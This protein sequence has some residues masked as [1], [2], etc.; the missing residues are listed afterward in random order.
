MKR[1]RTRHPPLG[2]LEL[3][4]Q[5]RA[6]VMERDGV[7]LQPEAWRDFQRMRQ[8]AKRSGIDLCVASSFR[9]FATQVRIWN[10]KWHG[11]RPL[12]DRRGRPMNAARLKPTARVRAILLW[13][14]PP[15]ASRHHWGSDLDVYDRAAL[16]KDQRLQLVPAEYAETGPFA[17]LTT[18]LNANMYRFGFYRPYT[19]DR[20]GVQ[21]EPWHLS[22]IASAR[23]VS[24][25]LRL[26]TL[27]RALASSEL[28]GRAAL[29]ANLPVV[30]SRFIR[31]VDRPPR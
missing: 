23:E 31:S 27:R 16:R 24:K 9:D 22:H 14:A 20:G 10:Q 17:A 5:S 6:H 3:T 25:R 15:G 8:A 26:P 19:T 7:T 21:P 28:G 4:G 13:S 12:L 11:E 30:Y 2:P 1:S 29:L 18:W